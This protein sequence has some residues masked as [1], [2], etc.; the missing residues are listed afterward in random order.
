MSIEP[1]CAEAAGFQGAFA[2]ELRLR[3]HGEPR[4][5]N[6]LERALGIDLPVNSQTP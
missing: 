4:P 1:N 2:L 5:R 6:R 3:V